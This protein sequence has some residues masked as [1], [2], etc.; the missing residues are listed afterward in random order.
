MVVPHWYAVAS[1]K[2]LKRI[3]VLTAPFV[4]EFQTGHY[5]YEWSDR[6]DESVSLMRVRARIT[7]PVAG[8]AIE[9]GTH[10]VRGKA[11]SGT[12]PI[13]EVG[14]SLTGEG[15]WLPAKLEPP[16]GPYHWQEWSFE[17]PAHEVGRHT[18]RARATDAAGNTQPEVP[19]WNRLGYG[20]NAIEVIYIDVC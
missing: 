16:K 5:M 15:D 10:T 3:D 2:W 20:N 6:P 9:L 18:L 8:S 14:V 13:T 1:V 11:W 12:G 4:G 19:P 7:A 17:W